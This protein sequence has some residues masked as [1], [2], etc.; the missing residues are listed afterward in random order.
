M[1]CIMEADLFKIGALAQKT[2]CQ[3][4]TVRFYERVGLLADPARTAS[5]HRVYDRSHE[6]RLRFIRRSRELDFSLEEIKAL[7]GFL[8]SDDYSCDQVQ[9][10]AE[11]HIQ[12]IKAK[13]AELRKM[14]KSLV[15]LASQCEVNIKKGCPLLDQLFDGQ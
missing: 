6:K 4:E 14:E 3:V 5:G 8:D 7:L 1:D 9:E 12:K 13:V 15:Q 2:G 10:F 11:E